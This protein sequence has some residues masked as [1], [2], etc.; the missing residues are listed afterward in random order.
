MTQSGVTRLSFRFAVSVLGML[1]IAVPAC[2]A[3]VP[4]ERV[5]AAVQKAIRWLYAQQKPGGHWEA[6]PRRDRNA[7]HLAFSDYQGPTHGGWTALVTF[8]L[9]EAGEKHTE[10]RLAKAITY[11][12]S[13]DL[14]SV[15]SISLRCM[16]FS[17]LPQNP[18]NRQML[19]A[20][21][22]RILA[23]R[24]PDGAGKGLWDYEIAKPGGKRPETGNI[25]HS[26]SQFGVLALWACAQAGVNLPPTIWRELEQQ[27]RSHQ[28]PD[29]GW[30]YDSEVPGTGK[31]PTPSMTCAGV[32]TLLIIQDIIGAA[33]PA[34]GI[35]VAPGEAATSEVAIVRGL[36]WLDRNFGKLPHDGSYGWYAAER[37]GTAGGYRYLGRHDWYEL[38]T[39]ALLASQG[40]DGDWE[41]VTVSGGVPMTPISETA[42]SILFL[43]HGRAPV[44]ISKLNY[45]PAPVGMTRDMSWNQR[46]RDVANLVRYTANAAEQPYNWEVVNLTAPTNDLVEVPVMYLSG[47]KPVTLLERERQKLKHYIEGGGLILAS[48]EAAPRDGITGSDAFSKSIVELGQSMFGYKFRELPMDHPIFSDQQFRPKQWKEKPVVWGLSNGVR[49][50][51]L[52][53]PLGDHGRSWNYN[54]VKSDPMK[55]EVGADILQYAVSGEPPPPKG[56][57]H[58]IRP[59]Y[60]LEVA[61]TQPTTAPATAPARLNPPPATGPSAATQPAEVQY[62]K[63]PD[64]ARRL[65]VGRLKVGDNWDPEP[66]GW[67]RITNLLANDFNLFCEVRPVTATP[68][69]LSRVKLLHW[70]GTT[71]V[72]LTD[73]ERAAIAAFIAAGGTLVVDAAGGSSAFA[74]AAAAEIKPMFNT[75]GDVIGQV[76]APDDPLYRLREAR[77]EAFKYRRYV[78]L[79]ATGKLNAPRLQGIDRAGRTIVFFSREDITG[80]CVG[81]NTDGISGYAPETA[82]AIMRNIALSVAKQR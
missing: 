60:L 7:D 35:A 6:E 75:Q 61:T 47:M 45:S 78:S 22:A 81:Q 19:E 82:T 28:H 40:K 41:G 67:R 70:T 71:A 57:S 53:L 3:P 15:Y 49:E 55:F 25:D 5:D 26:I 39:K 12:R 62:L 38:G 37:I 52:L 21:A 10:P 42:L 72:K 77:I 59:K 13:A 18:E 4:P 50:L 51:M 24:I 58:L 79:R 73:A 63:I 9:L 48:S 43:V 27:W 33:P 23:S 29:G 46:P 11:L 44:L 74:D 36:G 80:G 65:V 1:A 16:V 76:L 32:A 14:A 8:A 20:D 31:P 66:G 54:G 68:A 69:D 34:A 64:G 17:K 56:K 30:S 2:G